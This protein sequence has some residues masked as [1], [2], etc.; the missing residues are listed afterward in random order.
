MYFGRHLKNGSHSH[1]F[2]FQILPNFELEIPNIMLVCKF[3]INW[4]TNT[5]GSEGR[6]CVAH[7]SFHSALRK[8]NT[9]PSIHVGASHQVSVHLAKQLQRRRFLEHDQSETI[10]ACGSHVINDGN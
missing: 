8:L 10:M 5:R 4:S 9:E 2:F 3:E 1:N 7:L 6:A